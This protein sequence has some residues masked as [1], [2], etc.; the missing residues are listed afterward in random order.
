MA[1][2]QVARREGAPGV[3]RRWRGE[4]QSKFMSHFPPISR[5]ILLFQA[6]NH[7]TPNTRRSLLT[8]TRILTR[9]YCWFPLA[10]FPLCPCT[11]PGFSA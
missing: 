7:T 9:T 5:V 4:K 10:R 2:S 6:S 8:R 3:K 11:S 1:L